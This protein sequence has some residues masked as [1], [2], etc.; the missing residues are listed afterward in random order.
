[1]P[2]PQGKNEYFTLFGNLIQKFFELYANEWKSQGLAFTEPLI[3]QKLQ[4]LWEKLLSYAEV[5]WNAPFARQNSKEI[6]D[7]AVEDIIGNLDNLDVYGNIRSE[8]KIEVTFKSGDVLVGKLD[9]IKKDEEAPP[10]DADILDGKSTDK[11]G[12]NIHV[13]QLYT[14]AI[15]YKFKY[16]VYPK[17]IG[18]LYFRMKEIEYYDMDIEEIETFKKKLILTMFEIGKT[19]VFKATP[20]AKSC[21]YCDYMSICKE[22]MESA[23]SRKRPRKDLGI[24]KTGSPVQFGFN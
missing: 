7:N 1:V 10:E 5:D 6:F 23:N 12:K 17:R 14:Y 16:G 24:K 11:F 15:L 9:F 13:E 4:P 20:S 22:G 3:R 2:L 19:E 8:V 21:K 18:I